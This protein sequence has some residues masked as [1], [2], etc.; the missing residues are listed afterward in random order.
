MLTKLTYVFS[1]MLFLGATVTRAE[2]LPLEDVIDSVYDSVVSIVV[3]T[4]EGTQALGAGF[5]VGADGYVVT[6]AHVT[7]D[8][9]KILIVT[10]QGEHFSAQLTGWDKKTDVA[11]LKAD[12]PVGF[13]PAVFADSDR[14][15][16]GNRVFAVGN[17]FGLGNS[18]SLGIISAKERDIEKGPYDNF[19]QTDAAISQGN[20]GGPLFNTDGEIVGMNTAIFSTDGKFSGVGFATP[21][22]IVRWVVGQLKKNKT[23]ERGWLGI[24]MKEIHSADGADGKQLI[25]ETL[26][27][28]SPAEKA[29]VRG[30]D[31]FKKAADVSLKNPRMFSLG[32]AQKSPDSVIP[33]LIDRDGEEIELEITISKMPQESERKSETDSLQKIPALQSFASLGIDKYKVRDAVYF[34]KLGLKAYFDEV[35]RE[36]VIIS[37]DPL[38]EIASKGIKIGDRFVRVNDK[39]VFGVEDLQVKIKQAQHKGN[40]QLLFMQNGEPDTVVLKLEP[41][42]AAH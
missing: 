36:F 3:D 23:V 38:S 15:R 32:I 7:E 5:V 39:P 6:N 25:V 31:I 19:L 13:E 26:I 14:V 29:G 22:N 12:H 33:V 18:V 35:N 4:K 20:S 24:G 17:P 10:S 40:I 30:G 27:E 34:E 42:D 37:I 41:N 28:G 8:A 9:E 1:V 11:L 21:S 2:T 16:V